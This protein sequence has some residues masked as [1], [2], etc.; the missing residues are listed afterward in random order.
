MFPLLSTTP[1][2]TPTPLTAPPSPR[3]S[4]P[5]LQSV[6]AAPIYIPPVRELPDTEMHARIVAATTWSRNYHTQG[7]YSRA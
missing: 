1:T 5:R 4:L 3:P 2:P 7:A 6:V